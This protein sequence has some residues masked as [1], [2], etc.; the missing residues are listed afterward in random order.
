VACALAAGKG[1]LVDK[2]VLCS[3]GAE[4]EKYVFAVIHAWQRALAE[5][6]VA[7]MAWASLPV[8]FGREYLARHIHWLDKTVAAI[9]SRNDPYHLERF[10]EAMRGYRPPAEFAPRIQAPCLVLS[11]ADD[12]LVTP[13]NAKHLAMLC[14]GRHV[15]FPE[16]GHSLP[17]EAPGAFQSTLLEFLKK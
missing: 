4:H 1:H 17:A 6:G 12:P 7:A 5:G 9:T 16:T 2:L 10:L 14:A 8:V 11:G 3:L 13:S 15:V